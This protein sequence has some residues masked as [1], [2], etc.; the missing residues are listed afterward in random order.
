V[1]AAAHNLRGE[2]PLVSRTKWIAWGLSALLA[3]AL[4][5]GGD[6]R[7]SAK[8]CE[9]LLDCALRLQNSP[10]ARQ[11]GTAPGYTMAIYYDYCAK[12]CQ[13]GGAGELVD[14]VVK[15][16]GAACQMVGVRPPFD[17]IIA[18]CAPAIVDAGPPNAGYEACV[19]QCGKT[20]TACND[21]C[22]ASNAGACLDCSLGCNQTAYQCDGACN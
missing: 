11:C 18:T 9:I 21:A 6:S 16:F 17:Q 3:P 12:G 20:A 13:L 19:S 7:C 5:C 2:V 15:N 10:S 1:A 14:C 8:N 4:G 22:P